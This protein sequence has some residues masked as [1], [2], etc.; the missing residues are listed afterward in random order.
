MKHAALS[1]HALKDAVGRMADDGLRPM[2]EAA[3]LSLD[4]R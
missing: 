2:R 4:A 1:L 3:L